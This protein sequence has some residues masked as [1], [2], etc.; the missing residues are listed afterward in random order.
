MVGRN[1]PTKA[2][3]EQFNRGKNRYTN[4]L[5]YDHSRVRMDKVNG[6]PGSDYINANYI[7]GVRDSQEY[8]AAQGPLPGTKDDFWRMIWEENSRSIVMVTQTVERA[9]VKCDHYWPF[10]NEPVEVGDLKL[11]MHDEEILPEWTTRQFDLYDASSDEHRSVTQYHYTVWPDHGVPD[12]ASTLVGFIRYVRRAT[13]G[14]V[15]KY[16]PTVVHC[17]AG[18]GRTGTYIALDQLLH[19]LKRGSPVI[20]I[21]GIVYNMRKCRMFMVQTESQY[22]LLHQVVRD[23]L[24]NEYNEDDDEP[25]YANAASIQQQVEAENVYENTTTFH[26]PN[27]G[28]VNPALVPPS[29]DAADDHDEQEEEEEEDD[30]DVDNDDVEASLPDKEETS[31]EEESSSS[32]D[33][34]EHDKSD[35]LV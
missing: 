21:F 27:G 31:S 25:V 34:D 10:D 33:D 11:T 16:G 13:T 17:S 29:H 12:P 15:D 28:N 9:K 32:D 23:Y 18:V 14:L 26:H 20:D 5:P 4:I 1:Q 35:P 3:Q 19:I 24:N 22:I 8:I 30:D 7:A 6:Q 2:A